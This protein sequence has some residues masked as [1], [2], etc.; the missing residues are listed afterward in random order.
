MRTVRE[1]VRHFRC[2]DVE[3]K[4]LL[5]GCKTGEDTLKPLAIID[6]VSGSA[7]LCGEDECRDL[8]EWG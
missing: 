4:K 6:S 5:M 8:Y 3:C 2:S 7:E 1:E